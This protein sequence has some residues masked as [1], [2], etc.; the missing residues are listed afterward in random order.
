[1]GRGCGRFWNCGD[2]LCIGFAKAR[3]LHSNQ[4]PQVG[5][6]IL[7]SDDTPHAIG[8]AEWPV[9]RDVVQEAMLFNLGACFV[10]GRATGGYLISEL[11]LGVGAPLFRGCGCKNL[12]FFID[13]TS[14][15]DCG[16][17]GML[18]QA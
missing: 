15:L 12:A 17:R 4:L 10:I 1:M 9:R 11:V 13:T 6:P 5:A 8:D 2:I 3:D 16:R 14:E 7:L 18:K